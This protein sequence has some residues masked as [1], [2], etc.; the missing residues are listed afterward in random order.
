MNRLDKIMITSINSI[1]TIPSPKGRF[2]KM[3]N[4]ICYGLSFCISGKITYS[5]NGQKFV[6]D[7][8]H[9]ILL[10]QGQNYSIHGD[11]SGYF[12]VINFTCTKTS[13]Y[14]DEFIVYNLKNPESFIKDYERIK[15]LS[16][17][18]KNTPQIMSV[19]YD[20]ISRIV[21]DN[22]GDRDSLTSAITFLEQNYS[23][24]SLSNAML[25]AEANISE[26]YFRRL[27]KEVY[28]ISPHQYLLDIRIRRAKQLLAENLYSVT[29]IAEQC[30]FS[31]VYHFCRVFKQVTGQTPTEYAKYA[32]PDII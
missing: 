4:R 17:F 12:P 26:V 20:M 18:E 25:A 15:S 14:T 23:D 28:N 29:D 31:S 11:E 21:T 10:P 32:S 9:A 2:E 5:H 22:L 27:F 13:F 1:G 16:L 30:G 7:P 8:D 6:S 24:P 19:L 3:E